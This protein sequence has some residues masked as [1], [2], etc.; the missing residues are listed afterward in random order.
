MESIYIYFNECDSWCCS[1]CVTSGQL[2]QKH[3]ENIHVLTILSVSGTWLNCSRFHSMK[4]SC[5]FENPL[6]IVSQLLMVTTRCQSTKIPE[7]PQRDM[8]EE[9]GLPLYL[10]PAWSELF[11]WANGR[12]CSTFAWCSVVWERV[13]HRLIRWRKMHLS[14]NSSFDQ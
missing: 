7:S 6:Q 3:G 1:V 14:I 4:R 10:A 11:W 2:C 5:L 12:S 8:N 13:C 9:T